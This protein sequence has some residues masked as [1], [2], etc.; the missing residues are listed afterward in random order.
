M[1]PLRAKI[2]VVQTACCSRMVLRAHPIRRAANQASFSL[3]AAA[4][5]TPRE[6]S[7]YSLG[8]WDTEYPISSPSKHTSAIGF[9]R[10]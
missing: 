1:S 9:V 4:L 6:R 2:G 10:A 7:D 5:A 3:Q 8:T